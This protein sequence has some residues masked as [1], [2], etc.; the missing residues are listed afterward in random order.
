MILTSPL[1]STGAVVHNRAQARAERSLRGP[2]KTGH[3][4]G[5]RVNIIE[6]REAALAGKTVIT[7]NGFELVHYGFGDMEMISREW[8]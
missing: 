2:G 4:R 3:L 8:V 7:P 5:V 1:V 6:A